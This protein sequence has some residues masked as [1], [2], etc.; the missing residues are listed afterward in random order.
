MQSDFQLDNLLESYLI[1][2]PEAISLLPDFRS[3]LRDVTQDS[4]GTPMQ[5]LNKLYDG[6]SLEHILAFD[7]K[8][9]SIS[10][11]GYY[12]REIEQGIVEKM[13]QLEGSRLRHLEGSIATFKLTPA[14]PDVGPPNESVEPTNNVAVKKKAFRAYFMNAI[15]NHNNIQHQSASG[16]PGS[17][18]DQIESVA[19]SRDVDQWCSLETNSP[20]YEV[21]KRF[22]KLMICLPSTSV[23]IERAFSTPSYISCPLRSRL[24][25]SVFSKESIIRHNYLLMGLTQWS[26]VMG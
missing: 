23:M 6:K 24:R 1:E 18:A 25:A 26:T 12:L 15:S 2:D 3:W 9:M 22:C 10:Q 4:R 11:L 7:S 19:L 13:I 20:V 21:A 17:L 8:S 5:R 16:N 14:D